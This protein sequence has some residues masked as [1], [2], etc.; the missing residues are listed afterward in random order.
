MVKRLRGCDDRTGATAATRQNQPLIEIITRFIKKRKVPIQSDIIKH[1]KEEGDFPMRT[2]R[3]V[4][5]EYS[6]ELWEHDIKPG[7][8]NAIHYW[9]K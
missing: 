4:L 2:V 6:G 7:T 1:C 8:S 9:L 3:Q 5:R